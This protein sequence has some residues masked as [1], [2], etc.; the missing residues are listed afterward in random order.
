[1]AKHTEIRWVKYRRYLDEWL[2]GL[3]VVHFE[4]GHPHHAEPVTVVG[5]HLGL[6]SFT[7]PAINQQFANASTL[8]VLVC[9]QPA[10]I[11]DKII[12]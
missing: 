5:Y 4:A 1:M 8:P 12:F 3:F 10:S 11:F 6:E 2:W 9:E 7:Y